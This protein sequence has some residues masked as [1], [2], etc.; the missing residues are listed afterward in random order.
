[1]TFA[2]EDEEVVIMVK[3]KSCKGGDFPFHETKVSSAWHQQQQARADSVEWEEENTRGIIQAKSQVNILSWD[4]DS[5][6][7]T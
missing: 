3:R 1:M 6:S 4:F 5:N 7:V 2:K